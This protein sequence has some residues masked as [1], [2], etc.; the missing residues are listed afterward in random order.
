MKILL[1]FWWLFLFA[2]VSF[3]SDDPIYYGGFRA[4]GYTLVIL[5][6]NGIAE[7]TDF[8]KREHDSSTYFYHCRDAKWGFHDWKIPPEIK[9]AEKA[10]W[11]QTYSRDGKKKFRIDYIHARDKLYEIDKSGVQ[12]ELNRLKNEK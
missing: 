7:Y 12:L 11:V 2:S 6:E 4:D 5:Y 9:G 8:I 3:A 1:F 10:I